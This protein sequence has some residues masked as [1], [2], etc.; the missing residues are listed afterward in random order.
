MRIMVQRQNTR[1]CRENRK[2]ENDRWKKKKKIRKQKKKKSCTIRAESR[3][4]KSLPKTDPDGKG[5]LESEPERAIGRRR[6]RRER[7][8]VPHCNNIVLVAI[9]VCTDAGR[10]RAAAPG[11]AS[12]LPAATA[13]C[14]SRS[15]ARARAPFRYAPAHP[16]PPPKVPASVVACPSRGPHLPPAAT[17]PRDVYSAPSPPPPPRPSAYRYEKKKRQ[18]SGVRHYYYTYN[19]VTGNEKSMVCGNVYGV[20]RAQQT[21]TDEKKK[22]KTVCVVRNIALF[23][24]LFFFQLFFPPSKLSRPSGVRASGRTIL[25]TGAA[26]KYIIFSSL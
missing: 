9:R 6:R 25:T 10:V 13:T 22:N 2:T 24:S 20:G 3:G 8:A 4:G 14:A 18:V 21:R 7:L 12:R 26:G 1:A 17:Y 5:G 11:P 16:P 15:S 19:R 23:L